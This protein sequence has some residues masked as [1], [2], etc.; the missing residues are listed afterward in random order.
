MLFRSIDGYQGSTFKQLLINGN[1][2]EEY[3]LQ[4]INLHRKAFR[5]SK[6]G[7]AIPHL[8]KKLFKAIE[9]P[10]PPY[11]EQVKIVAAINSAQNRLDTIMENL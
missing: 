4:V 9:V 1:M 11:N 7:S 3:V 8:N 2:N 6:V 10:I 5:E